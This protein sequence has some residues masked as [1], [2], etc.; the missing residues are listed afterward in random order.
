MVAVFKVIGVFVEGKWKC[1]NTYE[2]NIAE[3]L[4]EMEKRYHVYLNYQQNY[5]FARQ[6]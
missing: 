4:L 1:P 6:H 2:T 5:N 3:Y